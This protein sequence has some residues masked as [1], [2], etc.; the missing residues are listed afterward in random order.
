MQT[1]YIFWKDGTHTL[2]KGKHAHRIATT[3]IYDM[4]HMTFS[5]FDLLQDYSD[6]EELYIYIEK[7]SVKWVVNIERKEV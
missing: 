2:L 1:V 4:E 5:Q 6:S 7:D 3:H